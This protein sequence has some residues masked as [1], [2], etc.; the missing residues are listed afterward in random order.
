MKP[1]NSV[2]LGPSGCGKTTL[3]RS[4]AVTETTDASEIYLGNQRID[5]MPPYERPVNTVFQISHC[6]PI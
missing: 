5:E 2:L 6:S 4:S 3:L 1:A